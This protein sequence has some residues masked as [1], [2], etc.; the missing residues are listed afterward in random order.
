MKRK[1]ECLNAIVS[2]VNQS[3]HWLREH[4]PGSVELPIWLN[5]EIHDFMNWS[6]VL[7]CPTYSFQ[8]AHKLASRKV[9]VG[10]MRYMSQLT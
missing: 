6:H 7:A 10:N 1:S 9:A 2:H 4:Q 8:S 3:L 5:P